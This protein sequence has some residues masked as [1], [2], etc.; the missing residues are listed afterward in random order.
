LRGLVRRAEAA[1]QL[2]P[3]VVEL[4]QAAAEDLCRIRMA[5]ESD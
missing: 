4:L 5:P 1:E 2:V 3:R